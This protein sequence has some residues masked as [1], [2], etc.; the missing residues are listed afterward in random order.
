MGW[1]C[2]GGSGCPAQLAAWALSQQRCARAEPVVLPCPSS[3][4]QQND[5]RTTGCPPGCWWEGLCC[6][7]LCTAWGGDK[8]DSFSCQRR[9]V[10]G[11]VL[12]CLVGDPCSTA[13]MKILWVSQHVGRPLQIP[14][15]GAW[16]W[17]ALQQA[18][19]AIF[20]SPPQKIFAAALCKEKNAAAKGSFLFQ[21]L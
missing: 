1:V 13:Q 19:R 8:W 4:S 6:A 16:C 20:P 5:P 12:P 14:G 18:A 15:F 3:H 21:F 17:V 11:H 2:A 10:T 9:G 7:P